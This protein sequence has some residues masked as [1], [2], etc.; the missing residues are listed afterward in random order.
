MSLKNH[1]SLIPARATSSTTA[2]L[3]NSE[4][5]PIC[6]NEGNDIIFSHQLSVI[7]YQLSVISYQLGTR[8]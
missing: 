6:N 2:G 3:S 8:Q 4:L 5:R 7:S 1:D